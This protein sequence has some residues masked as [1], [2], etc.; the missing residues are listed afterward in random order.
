[1]AGIEDSSVKATLRANTDELVGRGGFGSPT[2]FVGGS[3]MY[4]GN[5][6]LDLAFAAA[7][8]LDG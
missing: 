3:D 5:D 1:L 6:R 4:F 8:R 2:L 7:R